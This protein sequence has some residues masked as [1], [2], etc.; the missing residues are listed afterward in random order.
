MPFSGF[1]TAPERHH[2]GTSPTQARKMDVYSFGML[3]SWLLF[4][5]Q[6]TNR[7][8]N[9]KKDLEDSTMDPLHHVSELLQAIP[10]LAFWE[11][12]NLQELFK[13]TLA[14]NPAKR[15]ASFDDLLQLLIPYRLV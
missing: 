9:F 13:L 7:D 15:S 10:E 3:C 4:Y 2:R 6:T 8:R 1:W 12:D 5:N 14:Q 11:R